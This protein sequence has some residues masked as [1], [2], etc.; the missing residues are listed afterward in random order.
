MKTFK[1]GTV[2]AMSVLAAAARADD[3]STG[4]SLLNQVITSTG[5]VDKA[6]LKSAAG[7]FSRA[8]ASN[9]NHAKASTAYGI[10]QSAYAIQ[11]LID[12]FH[13]GYSRGSDSPWLARL[14]MGT[15]L[16]NM[17][18]VYTQDALPIPGINDIV[19]MRDLSALQ[20]GTNS[21]GFPTDPTPAQAQAALRAFVTDLDPAVSR[22]ATLTVTDSAPLILSTAPGSGRASKIGRVES[23]ALLSAL[24]GLRSI[25]KVATSYDLDFKT[26]NYN[27]L[28]TTVLPTNTTYSRSVYLPSGNF[29][30][31]FSDGAARMGSAYSD[32]L[33]I[34]PVLL[35]GLDVLRARTSD[36]FLV[37]KTDFNNLRPDGQNPYSGILHARFDVVRGNSYLT[38]AKNIG[39]RNP[40]TGAEVKVIV[41]VKALFTS[42]LLD[43]R[44]LCP[45]VR[46]TSATEAGRLVIRARRYYT[47][48]SDKTF[49]GL[50]PNTLPA[51]LVPSQSWELDVKLGSTFLYRRK[52][53]SLVSLL[54]APRPTVI[55]FY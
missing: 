28:C 31:R 20:Q 43:L 8:L 9:P 53:G 30:R 7:Y 41:N 24:Y 46:R 36:T 27:A 5:V 51:S 25:S 11:R 44:T 18:D 34:A 19:M 2:I 12:V 47:D 3:Y 22:L 42:P 17:S 39:F 16:T 38:T 37:R 13:L 26:Y 49:G 23:L 32:L 50:F 48:F 14:V 40:S 15:T 52:I 21:R 1:I 29:G 10:A 45:Q 55:K 6:K 54:V 4:V 33:K 35:S